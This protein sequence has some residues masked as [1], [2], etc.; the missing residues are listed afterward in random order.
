MYV[1]LS[2]PL[3]LPLSWL[4]VTHPREGAACHFGKDNSLH[5]PEKRQLS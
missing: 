2:F 3:S 5:I 1:I 4:Q